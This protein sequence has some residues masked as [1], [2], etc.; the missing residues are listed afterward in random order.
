MSVKG[1]T[2]KT[3]L[4]ASLGRKLASLGFKVAMVDADFDSSN[5]AEVMGI[6]GEIR[7]TADWRLL[8]AVEGNIKIFSMS[9]F[10]GDGKAALAKKGEEHRRM[11][12]DVLNLVEWGEVDYQ[13]ID[14]PPGSREQFQ[15]VKDLKSQVLIVSQPNTIQ[16]LYRAIDLCLRFRLKVLGVV[17][18]MAYV[19][20]PLCGGTFRPFG[21]GHVKEVAESY[22][23]TYLGEIP[24]DPAISEAMASGNPSIPEEVMNALLNKITRRSHKRKHFNSLK[25][26]NHT[27]D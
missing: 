18:N 13:I 16:D 25:R 5:L 10:L 26:L 27:R 12:L 6:N 8:P 19:R 14:L 11:I 17:E 7:R 4:A 3:L 20:C 21:G 23:F 9:L 15:V 1:G 2:G 22:G 24:L